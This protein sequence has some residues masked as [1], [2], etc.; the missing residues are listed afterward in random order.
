MGLLFS[1]LT[2]SSYS[3]TFSYSVTDESLIGL[4]IQDLTVIGADIDS[5]AI[6]SNINWTTQS[7]SHSSSLIN[8]SS[9]YFNG[10]SIG[11]TVEVT[12]NIDLLEPV[13]TVFFY[14]GNTRINDSV[15]LD[16]AL[17]GCIEESLPPGSDVLDTSVLSFAPTQLSGTHSSSFSL[18]SQDSQLSIDS[19]VASEAISEFEFTATDSNNNVLNL[20]ILNIDGN[21]A[22][23]SSEVTLSAITEDLSLIHI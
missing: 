18:D 2:P 8:F 6:S 20:N 17:I 23:T 13:K 22:P 14:F 16:Q 10:I 4:D 1:R 15:T 12:F 9:V 3:V 5:V 7:S 21:D 19:S 11:D